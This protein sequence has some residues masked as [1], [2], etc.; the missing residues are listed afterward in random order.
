M[1]ANDG[2]WRSQVGAGVVGAEYLLCPQGCPGRQQLLAAVRQMQQLLKGQETRFAE[3]LRMMKS[4]LSTLHAA[5]AKAAPEPAPGE[6]Q[7]VVGA[8]GWVSS[9]LE[10]LWSFGAGCY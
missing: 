9:A 10:A 8:L 5:L 7:G 6:C 2:T 3:G 4:R 1:G